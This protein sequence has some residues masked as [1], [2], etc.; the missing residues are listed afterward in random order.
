MATETVFRFKPGF[1]AKVRPQAA[2]EELERIRVAHGGGLRPAD[3]VD[4]ARDP[5]APLHPAFTWD[6]GV[7]A[8]EWRRTEAR[9]MISGL[10][11]VVQEAS[12]PRRIQ[13]FVSVKAPSL[14]RAYL[15]ATTV[16]A[17][18]VLRE[19]ALA[20]ALTQLEAW[21]RRYSHLEELG[22][23]FAAIQEAAAGV[24]A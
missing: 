24:A 21:R 7:A 11:I 13:A 12:G 15:P 1:S 19:R 23:L 8:E 16:M 5:A 2:G 10:R 9:R 6:D 20:E 18:E 4:E 22:D 3:V 17:D 14:G